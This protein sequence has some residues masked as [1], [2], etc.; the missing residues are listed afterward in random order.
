MNDSQDMEWW[1]A[2]FGRLGRFMH[3]TT[4]ES[5]SNAHE[6]HTNAQEQ[7]TAGHSRVYG[8]VNFTA[9]DFFHR[10]LKGRPEV[11]FERPRRGAQRLPVVAGRTVVFW[12]Y[13]NKD[14]VD[15]LTTKFGTSESRLA[16]FKMAR[17]PYQ[18]VMPLDHDDELKLS[19]DDLAFIERLG[20]AASVDE[21][22]VYPV[23]V[24]AYSS[25]VA[26]LYQVLCA[27]AEINGDGTLELGD[28]QRIST[29][30]RGHAEGS[31]AVKRFDQGVKKQF[32]L[33][34]KTANGA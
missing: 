5:L 34:S 27:D 31:K 23:S 11:T 13:A 15:V 2:R 25:N 22:S 18:E 28:I 24:V 8:P 17:T 33:K 32:D 7:I 20:D 26:G 6:E 3:D 10:S 12:R 14:G 9:Q 1:L 19:A 29:D 21:E 30:L 16:A 4:I